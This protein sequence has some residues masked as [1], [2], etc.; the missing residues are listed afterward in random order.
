MGVIT[1]YYIIINYFLT[2]GL[3]SIIHEASDCVSTSVVSEGCEVVLINKN[4]F[5]DNL[6]PMVA[7][8]LRKYVSLI[9]Y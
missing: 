6:T 9:R 7:N 3:D 1:P 4:F 2:K 8:R 5:A